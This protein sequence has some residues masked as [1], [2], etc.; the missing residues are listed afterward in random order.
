MGVL[1]LAMFEETWPSIEAYL[2]S[3]TADTMGVLSPE[4]LKQLCKTGAYQTWVIAKGNEAVGA[5]ITT[6]Q[7]AAGT[8]ILD[9]EYLGGNDFRTWGPP[10]MLKL[11]D[12]AKSQGFDILRICGRRG[13]AKLFPEYQELTHIIAKRL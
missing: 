9:I 5:F 4:L 1:N 13:W 10:L 12:T 7:E 8:K 11:E 3:A 2:V 6:Q